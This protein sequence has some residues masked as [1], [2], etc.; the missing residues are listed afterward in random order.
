MT[1]SDIATLRKRLAE[2]LAFAAL[3]GAKRLEYVLEINAD[4]ETA[5][6]RSYTKDNIAIGDDRPYEILKARFEPLRSSVAALLGATITEE[7][8]AGQVFTASL[9]LK[10]GTLKTSLNQGEGSQGKKR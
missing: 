5:S 7:L 8:S 10:D 4:G 1:D 3:P 9:D 2:I 6:L